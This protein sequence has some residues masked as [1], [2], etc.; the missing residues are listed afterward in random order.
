MAQL[1]CGGVAVH[2]AQLGCGGVAVHM[3]QL[4]CGG[5]A[6]H[7]AQLRCI[8]GMLFVLIGVADTGSTAGWRQRMKVPPQG[9]L[10]WLAQ[11]L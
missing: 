1:G 5:M 4:G 8:H 3:A 2:M 10:H 9:S 6:V 11:K 7:T